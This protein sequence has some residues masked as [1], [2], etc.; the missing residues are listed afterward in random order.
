M[1]IFV[2][3]LRILHIFGGIFW[4][5]A[6]WLGLFFLEPASRAL[7]PDGGKFLGYLTNNLRYAVYVSIAA[8]I[9]LLAGWT[10]F[11]LRY[12]IA[13][14]QTGPGLVF[15]IGG[16]LGLIAGVFGGAVV[17]SAS[18]QLGRLGAEIARAGKPPTSAQAAEMAAL[19]A[20]LRSG[21]LWTAV[22]TSL[23]V[24]MMAIAR[25]V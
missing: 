4:A 21:G 12:G 9:T 11:F 7:G 22:F 15:G 8:V 17:G 18:A 10:L 3:A 23:T 20:R 19:Q 2:I 24:L 13:G 14:L 16:V 5:G 6:A 1:D 25:Y